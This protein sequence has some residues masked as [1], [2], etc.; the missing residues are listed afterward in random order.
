MI[1]ELLGTAAVLG[2]AGFF[3]WE[4]HD[5]GTAYVHASLRSR[6]ATDIR[7]TPDWLDFDRDTLTYDVEYTAADGTRRRNTCKVVV[8]ANADERVFWSDPV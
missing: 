4:R 5:T 7:I 8:G 2:V 1:L 3:T 6:K